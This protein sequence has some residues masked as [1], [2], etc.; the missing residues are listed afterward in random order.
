MILEFF[1]SLRAGAVALA[2]AVLVAGFSAPDARAATLVGVYNGNDPFPNNLVIPGKGINS[3]A[4]AKCDDAENGR[5]TWE[6]GKA[7]GNYAAAFSVKFDKK[8]VGQYK[9]GTWSFDISKVVGTLKP[10]LP[11]YLAVKA[12]PNYAVYA[13]LGALSGTWNTA[14]VGNKGISHL[15]FFDTA[16]PPAPVPLP[17]AGLMLIGGLAGFGLLRRRAAAAA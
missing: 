11:S 6:D 4:L 9:S 5:C 12:G 10:L 15:S 3:P 14:A 1:G 13:L 7:P 17:A 16:P 2:A 8:V